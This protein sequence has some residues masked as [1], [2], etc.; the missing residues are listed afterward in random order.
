VSTLPSAPETGAALLAG[1]LAKLPAFLRRDLLT[2]LSY[3]VYFVSDV[4]GLFS[5]ALLFYFVSEMIASG[6][7]PS[8]GG[9]QT[10]YLE[11]VAI[12]V[13]V[14]VFVQFALTRVASALRQE[15][16][17]GTLESMIVTPTAPATIQLGSVVFDLFY[18]P[19]RT[20]VFL[21]VMAAVFALDFQASGVVPATVVLIAFIPFVWGL[22]VLGAAA[23]LTLRRGTGVAAIAGGLLALFSGAYFPLSLLPSWL[24][25]IAEWNPIVVALHGMRSSLLGG[26]DWG[27]T[28]GDVAILAPISL[29]SLVVGLAAFRVALRVERARGTLG[30]Y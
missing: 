17:Q 19:V 26:A 13:A 9:A 24:E 7:L 12:G 23:I 20:V 15:Q 21:G 5:Q 1:E 6:E 3:R 11:F 29:V 18:I 10:S 22:G 27:A 25:Q 30:I 8:Y 14:G 2:A 28:A 4:L 16:L